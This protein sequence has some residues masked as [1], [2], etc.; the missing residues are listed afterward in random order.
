[1]RQRVYRELEA[2]ERK[3]AAAQ[4]ARASRDGPSPGE[5]FRGLLSR[6]D[7]EQLSGESLAETVARAAEIGARDL[8]NLL[9]E[10]ALL[11]DAAVVERLFERC[12]GVNAEQKAAE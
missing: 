2:L 5:V 10:R 1:M 3:A 8:K 11:P 4:Q 7:I 9:W 6:Y 12:A